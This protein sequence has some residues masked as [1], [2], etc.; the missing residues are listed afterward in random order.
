MSLNELLPTLKELNRADKI[1]AVQFL[2]NEIA[3]EEEIWFSENQEHEFSSQYDSFEA[4]QAL[5]KLLE[6]EKAKANV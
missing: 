3:R 2:V 6:E 4:S 1:R 5:L